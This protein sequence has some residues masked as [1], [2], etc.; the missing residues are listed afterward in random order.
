MIKNLIILTICTIFLLACTDEQVSPGYGDE[1][2]SPL[3]PIPH[4]I[5]G[6]F[7]ID[8]HNI[9]KDSQVVHFKGVNAMQTF[10]LVNP[11]WMN[12]WK[13]QMVREF[14]GNLREQPISGSPVL[15]SDRVWYHPLQSIVDQNRAQGMVTILCPFG[16]VDANG[17]QT[18]LTGL[19]PSDQEFYDTYQEKMKAIAQ[20]FKD[21]PDVW[22]ELWNE[23]YRWDNKNN[24]SHELW[25]ND[26]AEMIDKL[27]WV[28]GFHNV[29]V[30]PGNEQG[31]SA[32]A[33]IEKGERL[34]EGRFNILFDLH[35]YE[36]WLLNTN[37]DQLAAKINDL[38]KREIPFIIG[39]VGVQ[40]IVGVMEIDPFLRAA[41]VTNISVLAWLWNQN[42]DYNNA[43]LT[44]D[45]QANATE[46]NNY[47]GT[48]Y[49]AFLKK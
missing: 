41:E 1:L 31:Q 10:G 17:E 36:K 23:P 37:E 47:W 25:L 40:N 30:V 44:K 24:Y 12:Q 32:D 11:N 26:M 43:L 29:I 46:R 13:V 27:R 34:L 28:D 4:K 5:K 8:G 39:E 35:A 22:I 45:G 49:K 21:Q 2:N 14:I 6:P 3:P 38:K 20:H 15:A 16:W 42:S 18:L 48:K 7:A 33:I 19:N 9:L